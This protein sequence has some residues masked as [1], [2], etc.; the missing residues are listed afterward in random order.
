MASALKIVGSF[1]GGTGNFPQRKLLNV[2]H[3][4]TASPEATLLLKVWDLFWQGNGLQLQCLIHKPVWPLWERQW[5][6]GG[7]GAT[8]QTN[9]KGLL[10]AG[11]LGQGAVSK[12]VSA[13]QAVVGPSWGTAL[14][15]GL[16]QP[17]PSLCQCRCC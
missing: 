9:S 15:G 17:D 12:D 8:G 7:V 4:P 5:L 10:L 14:L 16:S 3:L 11:C 6:D 13:Q 1:W 2:S